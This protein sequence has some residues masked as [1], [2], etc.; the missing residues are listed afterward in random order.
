MFSIKLN[1]TNSFIII[2]VVMSLLI[3]AVIGYYFYIKSKNPVPT[4]EGKDTRGVNFGY[5][6]NSNAAHSDSTSSYSYTAG[7]SSPSEIVPRLR[8]ITIEPIAGNDFVFKTV[9]VTAS[10]SSNIEPSD[11]SD[12]AAVIKA[13]KNPKATETIDTIRYIERAT[14]N[15]YETAT[16][17][18]DTNRLSN[19][20]LTN[21]YEAFFIG[22]GNSLI[23]R[24][25]YGDTDVI[26]T[27]YAK[28]TTV[29]P[30]STEQTLTT[31]DFPINITQAVRSPDWK[32]LFMINKAGATGQ[33]SKPD[34][35][36]AVSVFD[37]PFREWL[38]TWPNNKEIEL[39]T[40]PSGGVPG[41]AYLLNPSTSE[42]TR[43]IGGIDGL[44]T[45]MSPDLNKVLYSESSGGDFKL[46]SLDRTTGAV[47]DLLSRTLPEKCVWS[48]T[49]KDIIYCGIPDDIA[50]GLYPD[51]WY[52]GAI[53]F[54]DS[55]WMINTDTT[56]KRLIVSP[57]SE[58]DQP[59]DVENPEIDS[60]GDYL[61]FQNKIDLSLWG[62]N[63]SSSTS[64]LSVPGALN[65]SSDQF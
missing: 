4:F 62:L 53:N 47:T 2:V 37:S 11:T 45:L 1:R 43:I 6:P 5:N 8:H 38:A 39:N 15:I 31:T 28:L 18:L 50:F 48:T 16:N 20:T 29:S 42:L 36:S 35:G 23:L 13:S 14:G 55:I 56:E 12:V 21:L 33:I 9:S 60:T 34:G 10:S 58:V 59:I 3:G 54:S 44:T 27:R 49:Q 61:T 25:L 46:Y 7:T 17:T 63:L 22:D 24:G 41:Y 57:Q 64:T 19:T 40:K 26:Q 51:A 65:G 32:Q 52:Q 30:T